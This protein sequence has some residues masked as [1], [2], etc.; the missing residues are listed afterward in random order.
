MRVSLALSA[1]LVLAS[2]GSSGFDSNAGQ[3]SLTMQ[4]LTFSG[5]GID[6]QDLVG[7][8]DADVDVCQSICNFTGD[9]VNIEFET[10]TQTRADAIFMNMGAS[11][12]LL[13]KYTVTIPNSGVPPRTSS[14]AAIL[15]GGTCSNS[16]STQ[17]ASDRDCGLIATCEHVETSVEVLLFDFVTKEL[18]RGD[19][20]CPSID[21]DTGTIDPGN[22]VPQTYQTD[23]AFSG[24]DAS[25]KRFTVH[26]GLVA[27]FFDANNCQSSGN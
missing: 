5:E 4:F 16:A 21:F 8:T 19:H 10:F 26:A 3:D 7:N 11:P 2:C 27:G 18:V 22:V 20:R 13:D 1:A 9:L 12:I 17:C 25:G 6:Q 15:P 14:I 23:V 24:S